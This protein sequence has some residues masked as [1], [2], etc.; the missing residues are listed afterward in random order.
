MMTSV[1]WTGES[2]S[3]PVPSPTCPYELSPQHHSVVFGA[4]A[5]VPHADVP[6]TETVCQSEAVPTRTGDCDETVD[7]MPNCPK[8]LAPQQ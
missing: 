3:M 6:P 4:V 7:P 2:C 5:R 1:I 8:S